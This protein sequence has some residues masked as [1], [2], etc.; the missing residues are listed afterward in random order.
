MT[1]VNNNTDNTNRAY[2]QY[3]IICSKKAISINISSPD[4]FISD[5]TFSSINT[6]GQPVY[7]AGNIRLSGLHKHVSI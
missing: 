5:F 4:E 2:I 7:L 6:N 1:A 3:A